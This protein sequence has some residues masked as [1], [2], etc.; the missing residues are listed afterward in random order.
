MKILSQ[1]CH[2]SGRWNTCFMQTSHLELGSECLNKEISQNNRRTWQYCVIFNLSECNHHGSPD[3]VSLSVGTTSA[4]SSLGTQKSNSTFFPSNSSDVHF[5]QAKELLRTLR[6][7][8][9]AWFLLQEVFADSLTSTGWGWAA[10]STDP[11]RCVHPVVLKWLSPV[12]GHRRKAA[13]LLCAHCRNTSQDTCPCSKGSGLKTKL[14]RSV[15]KNPPCFR[16][17]ICNS[18]STEA[19]E[20]GSKNSF[21]IIALKIMSYF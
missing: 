7:C 13:C 12:W 11:E 14:S 4:F 18:N 20:L 6:Q 10:V 19:E 16:Y 17:W 5:C 1:I 9:G 3:W 21:K 8:N 15:L 2:D